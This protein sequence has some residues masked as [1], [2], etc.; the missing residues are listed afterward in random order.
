MLDHSVSYDGLSNF[1]AK[2]LDGNFQVEFT[3]AELAPFLKPES[4]LRRLVQQ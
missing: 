4:P 2:V 3:H 1:V